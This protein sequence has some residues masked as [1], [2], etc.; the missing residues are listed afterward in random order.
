M[1]GVHFIPIF[2]EAKYFLIDVS[3]NDDIVL[4]E[5]LRYDKRMIFKTSKNLLR[6]EFIPKSYGSKEADFRKSLCRIH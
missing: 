6:T 3:E 4:L 1:I 5:Y 2:I